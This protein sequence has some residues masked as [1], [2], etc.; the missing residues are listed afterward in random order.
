MTGPCPIRCALL[1]LTPLMPR[2]SPA[3]PRRR[4]WSSKKMTKLQYL[5]EIPRVLL[6][7]LHIDHRHDLSMVSPVVASAVLGE[8]W[9]LVPVSKAVVPVG[10][11]VQ[12][13]LVFCVRV[14]FGHNFD[15]GRIRLSLQ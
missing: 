2:L 8:T 4:H 6:L 13:L 3:A 5:F 12:R 7:Y 15:N 1:R 11:P 14:R 9:C 10:Q